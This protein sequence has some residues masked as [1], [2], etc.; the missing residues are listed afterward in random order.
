MKMKTDNLFKFI[1]NV[2]G[3]AIFAG[4][5]I[6]AVMLL[7]ALVGD[8]I[9]GPRHV[10]A[11]VNLAEDNKQ[12]ENWQLGYGRSIGDT[13]YQYIPLESEKLSVDTRDRHQNFEMFSGGSGYTPTRAKNVLFINTKTNK[14]RW[15]FAT[16]DQIVVDITSLQIGSYNEAARVFGMSY[17]VINKDTNQ[18]GLLDNK[19]QSILAVSKVDGSRYTE[20]LTGHSEVI[21][22]SLNS[23]GNLF[24]IYIENN[25]VYSMIFDMTRF[26]VMAKGRLP[27]VTESWYGGAKRENHSPQSLFNFNNEVENASFIGTQSTYS[28]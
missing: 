17:D 16:V 19:D 28:G 23:D 13:D 10:P 7:V 5:V 25:E 27:K 14:A 26:K 3:L 11:P 4:I 24:V 22:S 1:W 20:V 15:L 12:E 18:D 6:A 2:N 8:I 9:D 21:E